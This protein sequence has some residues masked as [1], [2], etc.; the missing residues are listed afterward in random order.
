[1]SVDATPPHSVTE[2]ETV[3]ERAGARLVVRAGRTVVADYGSAAGELAACVT[4]VGIA[5]CSQLTKLSLDGPPTQLRSLATQLAGTELAPGG[6]AFNGGA[7]WCAEG[8]ARIVVLCDPRIGHRLAMQLHARVDRRANVTLTDHTDDW[9]AIAVVGRRARDLL[10][11]LGVY[12]ESGDPRHAAPFTGHTV[13]GAE[14]LWLLESDSRAVA[15]MPTDAAASVW[16]AIEHAGQPLGIC[17]VG[18]EAVARYALLGRTTP[19][20]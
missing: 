8:A 10:S 13:T 11:V 19:G 18:A 3:Q 20:L 15:L 4:A 6:A 9:A 17:A 2:F 1:M 5:D 14:L 12:G 16:H 7:W